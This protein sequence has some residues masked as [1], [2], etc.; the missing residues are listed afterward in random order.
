MVTSI[1]MKKWPDAPKD[2]KNLRLL[3]TEQKKQNPYFN[4]GPKRNVKL[5]CCESLTSS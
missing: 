2:S 5:E 1:K 3:P 4:L